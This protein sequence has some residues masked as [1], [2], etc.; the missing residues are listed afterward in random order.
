MIS[1]PGA[2]VYQVHNICTVRCGLVRG[3][4]LRPDQMVTSRI[5]Y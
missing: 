4:E 5:D 1:S 2:G 3:V